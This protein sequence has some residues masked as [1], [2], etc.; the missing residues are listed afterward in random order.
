MT[1]KK[2]LFGGESGLSYTANMGLSL[3]RMFVGFSLAF[4]HGIHKIPPSEQFIAG[5]ANLGFPL[6][7]LFSWAAAMSEFL[8]GI[9]LA[10]G[11]FTRVSSFFVGFTML[12]AIIGVHGGDPY[13]K[14]ELA[15]VYLLVAVAYMIKG[16][17]DWSLDGLLRK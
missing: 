7:V 4:T 13:Q 3:L 2:I 12:V 1:L 5:T 14:K 9:F 11:L 16:S 15:F 8:G 17:G 6:P 10:V